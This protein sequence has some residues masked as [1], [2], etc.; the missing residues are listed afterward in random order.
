MAQ[1]IQIPIT[2]GDLAFAAFSFLKLAKTISKTNLN[3]IKKFVE[4]AKKLKNSA[5]NL[6]ESLKRYFI[7]NPTVV[8][9]NLPCFKIKAS[10]QSIQCLRTVVNAL[11]KTGS[12]SN[13]LRDFYLTNMQKVVP[14][15]HLFK[16]YGEQYGLNLIRHLDNPAEFE[17][18]LK[19]NILKDFITTEKW[20]EKFY[21]ETIEIYKKTVENRG[22]KIN[23]IKIKNVDDDSILYAPDFEKILPENSKFVV[24][25]PDLKINHSNTQS[26]ENI[27]DFYRATLE[28]QKNMGLT[29][30]DYNIFN[31]FIKSNF[32]WHHHEGLEKMILLPKGVHNHVLPHWGAVRVITLAGNSTDDFRRTWKESLDYDT[33]RN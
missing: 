15:S 10:T 4:D 24:S 17:K 1:A 22:V 13:Q 19:S 6:T 26:G 25:I 23:K 2:Y 9:E 3:D 11:I 12:K 33:F 20:Q 29:N 30:I 8:L 5:L 31:T 16:K 32:V 27:G 14:I 7:K 21:K 28:L 18:L